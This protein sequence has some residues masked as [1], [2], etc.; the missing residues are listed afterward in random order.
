MTKAHDLT[1]GGFS[2]DFELRGEGAAFDEQ[3]MI[4]RGGEILRHAAKDVGIAVLDGRSLAVHQTRRPDDVSAK[5]MANRLVAE[6]YSQDRFYS[7]ERLDNVERYAG[8]SRGARPGRKEHTFGIKRESFSRSDFVIPVNALLNSQ[9]AKVL[10]QVEGERIV[11]VDDE[12]HS[13]TLTH[14]AEG[15]SSIPPCILALRGAQ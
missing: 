15:G 1:L 14:G 2:G 6:A 10:D 12:K 7:R 13:S 11:V 3:R 5:I 4:A 8:L 9:L